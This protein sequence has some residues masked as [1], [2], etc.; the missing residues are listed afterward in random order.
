MQ[1]ELSAVAW[2]DDAPDPTGFTAAASEPLPTSV[3]WVVIGGGF[4]GLSAARRAA[5]RG[6]RV[7]LLEKGALR[8]GA[9]SR[10]GGMAH[11]GFGASTSSIIKRF[12]AGGAREWFDL[13]RAAVR[14]VEAL[15]GQGDASL[16]ATTG[17]DAQ[18]SGTGHV[19]LTHSARGLPDLRA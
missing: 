7:L 9:S 13:S 19:E 12:G 3:E 14:R 2:H 11:V 18:W 4:S 1:R 16:M 6:A 5:E 10:N 15:A 8:D 17:I